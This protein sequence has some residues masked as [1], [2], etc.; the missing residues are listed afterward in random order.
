MIELIIY[1][2]PSVLW[3]WA[4]WYIGENGPILD[5]VFGLIDRV[6]QKYPGLSFFT[7]PLYDC[8]VCMSSVHGAGWFFALRELG[9]H[10]LELIFLFPYV[11]FVCGINVLINEAI[12]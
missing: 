4:F 6:V 5:K 7:K 3:I 8:P 1:A 12:G 10:D 9:F 2:V 11:M